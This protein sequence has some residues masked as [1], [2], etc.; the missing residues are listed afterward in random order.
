MVDHVLKA[1][2]GMTD[3]WPQATGV[4]TESSPAW[5]GMATM[6]HF[7]IVDCCVLARTR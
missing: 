3:S 7:P 1:A 5:T 6:V 4:A 2:T